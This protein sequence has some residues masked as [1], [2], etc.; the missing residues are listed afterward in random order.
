MTVVAV[1]AHRQTDADEQVHLHTSYVTALERAGLVPLVLPTSLH[2]SHASAALHSLAGLVLSG[3]EDVDPA[4]YG[5]RPHPQLGRID[6]QRDEVEVTL[7]RAALDLRIPVLA[8]CRGMQ[9]L[10]VALGGSLFQ[11]LPSECPGP[12]AHGAGD[13]DVA[14]EPRSLLA[15]TLSG[16]SPSLRVNSRHHQALKDIAPALTVVGRAP[17]GVVEAVELRQP[18]GPWVIGVQWHPEDIPDI[19]LFR[20]FAEAAQGVE[21]V[22]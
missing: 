11:D 10:N 17:D 13:H 15:R 20:G 1:T 8:I 3:G 2:P 6:R 12:V 19:G 5:A 4:R 7:A 14:I 18:D 22:G 21:A 9:I 16:P